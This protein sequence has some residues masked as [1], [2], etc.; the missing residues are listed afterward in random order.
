MDV[1]KCKEVEKKKAFLKR[2]RKQLA[3]IQRIEEKIDFINDRMLNLKA[4]RIS[5]EPRGTTSISQ[6]ELL[7][8]KM[9]YEKRL[10][11]L[12]DKAKQIKEE[13]V[14]V[15]DTLDD[16][17]FIEVLEAYFIDCLSFGQI[18]DKLGYNERWIIE[19]YSTA[20]RTIDITALEQQ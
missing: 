12:K 3:K 9:D 14:G 16:T 8:D 6:A 18:A 5:D 10:E 7:S 4:I 20:I 13:I 2:Y 11:Y 19:L 15:I 1:S 17:R